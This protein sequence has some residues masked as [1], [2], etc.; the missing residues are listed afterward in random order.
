MELVLWLYC[1]SGEVA[2]ANTPTIIIND[3]N[4]VTGLGKER[5]NFFYTADLR[6]DYWLFSTTAFQYLSQGWA[7]FNAKN[8]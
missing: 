3:Y 7:P 8:K 1:F 6:L 5:L 4:K 2:Q